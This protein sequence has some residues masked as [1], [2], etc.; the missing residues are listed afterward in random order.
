MANRPQFSEGDWVFY[1]NPGH[2]WHM[3]MLQIVRII[4]MTV[5]HPGGYDLRY[6]ARQV[7]AK[8][9]QVLHRRDSS[10]PQHVLNQACPVIPSIDTAV[11]HEL[12]AIGKTYGVERKRFMGAVESDREYRER[13]WSIHRDTAGNPQWSVPGEVIAASYSDPHAGHEV[14]E[15]WAGGKKFHYCRKCKVEVL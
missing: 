4:P 6:G 15:N 13:L 14:I 2:N 12:E 3:T 5:N 7:V 9:N 11:G 8:V 1:F 10:I